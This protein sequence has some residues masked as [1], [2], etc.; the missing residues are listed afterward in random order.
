MEHFPIDVNYASYEDLL[1]VPG[2][3]V[4]SAKRII[5]A[6]M[7]T[8]L[9]FYS[10]KKLGIVLKRAQYFIICDGKIAGNV[11]MDRDTV[12]K[13]LMSKGAVNRYYRNFNSEPGFEQ[14]SF[15]NK[16]SLL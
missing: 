16:L 11:K 6:R 13:S 5:L 2:I 1:R 12:L 15:F 3:G 14:L 10:L 8:V 4:R 9:D 7:N